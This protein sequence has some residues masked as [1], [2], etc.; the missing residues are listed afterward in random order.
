MYLKKKTYQSEITISREQD[1]SAGNVILRFMEA[2]GLK[3]EIQ[4]CFKARKRAR[5]GRRQK[6]EKK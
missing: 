1:S 5:R 3:T 6:I 4:V 2:A